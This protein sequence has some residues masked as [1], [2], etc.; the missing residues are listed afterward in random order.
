MTQG[1]VNIGITGLTVVD[2]DC[3]GEEEDDDAEFL[4]THTGIRGDED[5]DAEFLLTHTGI[6]GEE[7]DDADFLLTHT[8]LFS[9]FIKYGKWKTHNYS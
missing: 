2:L 6:R 1:I 9:V 5:D 3:R 8:G 4:L 7:G